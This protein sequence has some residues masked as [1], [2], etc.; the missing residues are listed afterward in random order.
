MDQDTFFNVPTK[1][2]DFT[3]GPIS[4]DNDSLNKSMNKSMDGEPKI[5]NKNLE[6]YIK[7][8]ESRGKKENFNKKFE[9][10]EEE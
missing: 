7:K 10:V 5:K 4:K 9:K 6:N 1:P 8:M 3:L 2:A